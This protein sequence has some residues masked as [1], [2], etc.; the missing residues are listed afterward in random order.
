MYLLV[1]ALLLTGLKFYEIGPFANL[2]WL[3]I[4]A[5][6]GATA[7]WWIW[8]DWSGFTARKAQERMDD[9]KKARLERQR[10]QLGFGARKKR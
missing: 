7:L 9:V 8:S 1:L 3:W 5:V 4:L 2:G 6:Y 10:A